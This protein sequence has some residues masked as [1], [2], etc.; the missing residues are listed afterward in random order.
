MCV[1]WNEREQRYQVFRASVWERPCERGIL[2]WEV[3]DGEPLVIVSPD[4]AVRDFPVPTQPT[5]RTLKT[6]VNAAEKWL[7]NHYTQV[8]IKTYRALYAESDRSVAV[9]DL[10]PLGSQHNEIPNRRWA[11]FCRGSDGVEPARQHLTVPQ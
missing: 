5:M 2:P 11:G 9:T 4:G 1:A 8:A 6:T 7:R 10:G 3:P